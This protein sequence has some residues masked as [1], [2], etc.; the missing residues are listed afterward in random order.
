MHLAF[1]QYLKAEPHPGEDVHGPVEDVG[2]VGRCD[3]EE[4]DPQVDVIKKK[5]AQTLTQNGIQFET[6][7]SSHQPTN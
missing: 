2:E 4:G 5:F 3:V 7:R 6:G 1:S